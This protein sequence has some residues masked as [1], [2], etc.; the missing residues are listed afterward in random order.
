MNDPRDRGEGRPDRPFG[1]TV[2]TLAGHSRHDQVGP[3][4]RVQEVTEDAVRFFVSRRELDAGPY[5]LTLPRTGD[6]DLDPTGTLADVGVVR[7]DVLVLVSRTPQV[8]G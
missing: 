6:T 5:A 3:S 8:D 1:V 7:D 2:R 4:D